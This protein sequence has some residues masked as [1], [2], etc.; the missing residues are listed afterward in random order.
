[1]DANRVTIRVCLFDCFLGK[2][3]PEDVDLIATAVSDKYPL[4]FKSASLS[5]NFVLLVPCTSFGHQNESRETIILD[6]ST[7]FTHTLSFL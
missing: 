7:T 4:P 6:V 5:F 1:M 2:R 3:D